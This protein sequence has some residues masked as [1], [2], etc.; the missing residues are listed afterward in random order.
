MRMLQIQWWGR[1]CGRAL[2]LAAGPVGSEGC[3]SWRGDIDGIN[4]DG[5]GGGRRSMLE[6]AGR[7]A[8]RVGGERTAKRQRQPAQN[9]LVG[10]G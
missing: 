10:Y 4:F 2:E 8:S 6:N 7:N 1:R 9:K 3:R 5:Q